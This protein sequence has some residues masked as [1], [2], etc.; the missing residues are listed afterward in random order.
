MCDKRLW[1]VFAIMIC[2]TG[3]ISW[4]LFCVQ[5]LDGGRWR[6]QAQGQQRYF[7]Q[8]QGE[9]GSIYLGSVNGSTYPVAVNKVVYH[10]YVAP[11]ELSMEIRK[12]ITP[13]IAEILDIDIEKVEEVMNTQSGYQ[14]LK[15]NLSSE[16]IEMVR[17]LDGLHVNE[18]VVRN[19]PEENLAAHIIGFVGGE[20]AGQYGVEQYYE[21]VLSG[22]DGVREGLKNPFGSLTL[23]DSVQSGDDIFLTIDYNIQHFVERELERG[24][25]RSGAQGGTVVVGNPSTGEIIAMAS[26]PDFNPND[27]R[28]EEV[29]S[30]KNPALQTTFE[31]GS[32]FKPITM[33]IALNEHAVKPEDTF[34]DTGE[35]RVQNW[36]V[37]NYGRR[38]FGEV[39]M[40]RIIENSINTGIVYVKDRVGNS[41]FSDYLR[42]FG[43]FEH[44][45]IDLH[46]EVHSSNREF[47]EGRDINYATASYGQGIEVNAMQLFR[48]F[49]I[50]ANGGRLVDPHIVKKENPAPGERIISPTAALLTTEMMVNTIERGFGRTAKVPGYHI[51]GKTGTAQVSWSKLGISRSG[52]SD[53]TIQGFIGYAPAL[54]PEFVIVVKL[55]YPQT[56][57]AE[58]SAAPVFRE[59][60]KYILEY[61][62]IPYDYDVNVKD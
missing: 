23:R 38:A 31:P 6:A 59:I 48:G 40:S 52:Y 62:K 28:Q 22:R 46:G 24:I 2:L 18:E 11:R 60:A 15:R 54:D 56:T 1:F 50:L 58:V 29:R 33:A 20:G 44:T 8:A 10:A 32:V 7:S 61:K 47:L 14:V 12:E 55:D 4:R 35:K 19:Y 21:S 42:A 57:S 5:V 37:R 13:Q 34:Y 43:F 39:D 36:T 3:I 9:R 16:E 30:F 41:T 25:E 49:S 27:Y 17:G 53:V 45:G 51:A 26:K